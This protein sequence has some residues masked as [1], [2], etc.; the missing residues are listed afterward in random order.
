[1]GPSARHPG[2]LLLLFHLCLIL[3][4]QIAHAHG[5]EIL[6]LLAMTTIKENSP[7]GSTVTTFQVCSDDPAPSVS[8]TLINSL[9]GSL[10]K[11]VIDARLPPNI[12]N[13]RVS[14]VV[15]QQE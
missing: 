1:M 13:I 11:P 2:P 5:A 14:Q 3:K 15:S 6:H 10:F 8:V 12:S 9:S 4:V 7:I